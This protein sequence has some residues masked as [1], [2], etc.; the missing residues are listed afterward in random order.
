MQSR[1][2]AR[3]ASRVDIDRVVIF[4]HSM[5]GRFT[6]LGSVSGLHDIVGAHVGLEGGGQ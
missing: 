1:W 2:V 6:S 3:T 5:N 4:P